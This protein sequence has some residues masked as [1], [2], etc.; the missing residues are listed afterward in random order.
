MTAQII[1]ITTKQLTCNTKTKN[2]KTFKAPKRWVDFMDILSILSSPEDC[3]KVADFYRK[4]LSNEEYLT[5]RRGFFPTKSD[6][7][8]RQ[9]RVKAA[10]KRINASAKQVEALQN[11]YSKQ[12]GFLGKNSFSQADIE[13]T[14]DSEL[15]KFYEANY[16]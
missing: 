5:L 2:T 4:H 15:R 9:K 12:P 8:A 6:Q 13:A 3:K 14:A 1:K 7:K 10:Q 11:F 16:V